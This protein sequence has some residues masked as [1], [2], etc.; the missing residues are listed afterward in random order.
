[1]AYEANY[2]DYQEDSDAD[3]EYERSLIASPRLPL[4]AD[5][6]SSPTESDPPSNENTPTTY[7][8]SS[9]NHTSPTGLITDWT[10]DQ[11]AYWVASLGFDQ[12]GDAIVGMWT[13][14]Y[15]SE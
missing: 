11:C 1:M 3:D 6:E 9:T 15:I 2:Q 12:Y 5:Y 10:A 14:T 13:D 7:T 4:P 8:H